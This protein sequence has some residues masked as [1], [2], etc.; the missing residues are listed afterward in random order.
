[1]EPREATS[2]D[3]ANILAS[4]PRFWGERDPRALHRPMFLHE[5]GDTALVMRAP[6]DEV[7]A[8]L[9]GFVAPA[10]A[11]GYVHLVGVRDSHRRRG[12]GRRLYAEFERRSRLRGAAS[13]KAI[14]TPG[15]PPASRW[16]KI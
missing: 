9:L 8:Y 13:M 10:T 14:A 1:V 6:D 11:V 16:A 5:F 2:E 3:Y 15:P 12:L 7:V 4:L